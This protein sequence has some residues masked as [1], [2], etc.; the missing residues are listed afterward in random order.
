M[1]GPGL[2][3]ALPAPPLR[4]FLLPRAHLFRPARLHES[5]DRPDVGVRQPAFEAG[6]GVEV[7]RR[8]EGLAAE[9]GD[10]EQVAVAAPGDRAAA[11]ERLG[12]AA[13]R[14]RGWKYG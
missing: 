12:T 4:Q 10:V 7:V 9:L 6:H 3:F 13:G 1:K 2:V 5:E 14:E 8:R 11:D